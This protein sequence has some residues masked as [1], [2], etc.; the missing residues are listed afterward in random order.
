MGC[1]TCGYQGGGGCGDSS[2][3]GVVVVCVGDCDACGFSGGCYAE[4]FGIS[5][6]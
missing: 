4:E 6:L 3:G 5:I 2:V 1:G